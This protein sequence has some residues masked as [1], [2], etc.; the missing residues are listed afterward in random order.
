MK[1]D[2]GLNLETE[3]YFD[4]LSVGIENNYKIAKEARKQG[5]D[6][7][8]EVEVPLALTMAAKVV[9][10]IATK[11][12]QLDNEDIINRVLELEK[13]YGALD[14][15]VSFVIAEEIAK[16]KYCKFETQLEAMDAG[17]RVGFAYT[18]LG[19]V[20]SP[21][22]GFTEI[23][24]GKTQLGETYLKAFFFRAYKECR[25]NCYLRGDYFNRLY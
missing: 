6:P 14:N 18:T 12:S 8:D 17:I 13:K 22:E 5:L 25:Y 21:I 2:K 20:S 15:T 23:Q 19:V 3:K 10:L 11:Y 4:S 1:M 24:T 9:R 16:E 7:V